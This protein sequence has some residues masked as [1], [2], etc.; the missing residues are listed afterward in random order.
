MTENLEVYDLEGRLLGTQ[1]RDAFYAQNKTEFSLKG[2]IT[3]QVRTVRA[4]LITSNG[5]VY[6]PRRSK[7][8]KENP[9]LF[10]KSLGGHVIGSSY[11]VTLATEAQQEL[12]ITSLIIPNDEFH[13]ALRTSNLHSLAIFRAIEDIAPFHSTRITNEGMRF[14]Q[15]YMNRFY[16]GYYDG[17]VRFEDG[18]CDAIQ[19]FSLDDLRHELSTPHKLTDDLTFMVERYGNLIVPLK[20]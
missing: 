12:G 5:R 17:P 7:I 18:E 6:I 4:I 1:E 2:E 20:A 14:V 9:G 15:P 13:S 3:R 11:D 10:D 19:V 8:K 16:L